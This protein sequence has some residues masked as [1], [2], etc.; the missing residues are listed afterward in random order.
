MRR[1]DEA[2][3]RERPSL[4]I[5]SVYHVRRRTAFLPAMRQS[6]SVRR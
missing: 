4:F 6:A 2:R 1:A 3:G 5:E